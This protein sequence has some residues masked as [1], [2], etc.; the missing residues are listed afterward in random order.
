MWPL[1]FIKTITEKESLCRIWPHLLSVSSFVLEDGGSE[2]EAIAALLHDALEDH[3]DMITYEDIASGFGAQVA[4]IVRAC[5]DTPD[6]F[7]GGKKPPWK[8]RKQ[9]YLGHLKH[10]SPE[11]L[12]VALADKLHNSSDL[13]ADLQI[14]GEAVWNRFNAGK[15]DQVWFYQQLLKV[16]TE[17]LSANRLLTQFSH[18]VDAIAVFAETQEEY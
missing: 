10:S 9:A 18:V 12:R 2:D 4:D 1:T 3:P 14:H 6:D 11:V 17:R 15:K 13:L 8:E 5:S 16:F 7:M